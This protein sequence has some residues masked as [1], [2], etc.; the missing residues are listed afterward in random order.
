MT[1]C[2]F[3]QPNGH[4]A[5]FLRRYA[6][7]S[8]C[9]AS[10][11]GYHNAL[12]RIGTEAADDDRSISDDDHPRDDA[13]WPMRCACGYAFQASDAWQRMVHLL[14]ARSDG[15]EPVTL[16]EAPVG[17]MWFAP[18]MSNIPEY[19]GPDG[20]TL[21][22]RLPGGHDWIVDSRANNCDSPC[23]HC[24]KPYHAHAG[25]LC[26]ALEAGEVYDRERHYY[27]DARPHK[28]WVR[29]G[30]PPNVHV[31][32][33]GVTCNAGAGS[34]AY[35]GFHGFLHNGHIVGC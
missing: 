17:A 21:T 19:T 26:R 12:A 20:R 11:M 35:P 18:W 5:I 4:A 9:E 31:D 27:R 24:G 1:Q 34:I 13:R 2:I 22:V 30:E 8:K 15:G 33:N 14:Y 23:A 10:G 6:S 7:G 25:G 16:R 29:H 28:C 32:K 3:L